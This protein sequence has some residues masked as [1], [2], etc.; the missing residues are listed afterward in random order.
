M[1]LKYKDKKCI[2]KIFIYLKPLP[3]TNYVFLNSK[4]NTEDNL[5]YTNDINNKKPTPY[6]GNW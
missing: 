5:A 2:H 6:I 4:P 3:S 1:C